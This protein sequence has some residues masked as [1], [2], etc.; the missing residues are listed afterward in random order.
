MTLL[1]V[2]IKD[3]ELVDK[4]ETARAC[5]RVEKVWIEGD[6]EKNRF[7][8]IDLASYISIL[9][10]SELAFWTHH[11]ACEIHIQSDTLTLNVPLLSSVAGQAMFRC[12]K[13]CLGMWLSC[14]RLT[15]KR[16]K[17]AI[18]PC[19]GRHFVR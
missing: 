6:E 19:L 14:L 7:H 4:N 16:I 8:M 3:K 5:C 11:L 15:E 10:Q 2:A 12:E 13:R 17:E 9:L 18:G 1:L